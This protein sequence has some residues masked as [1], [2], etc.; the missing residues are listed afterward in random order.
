MKRVVCINDTNQPEGGELI[1][2]MEYEVEREFI[3]DY[4]QRTYVI[5]GINNFGITKMGMRWYGYNSNRFS[6][7][8]P[9]RSIFTVVEEETEEEVLI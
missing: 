7:A 4:D 3:N 2:D 8:D 1:K 5:S 6:I 9:A